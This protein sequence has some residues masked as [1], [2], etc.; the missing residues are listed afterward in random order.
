MK[1][2]FHK[3]MAISM[4]FVVLFSTMSFSVGLHYCGNTL[5][6]TALFEKAKSCGMEL[7]KKTSSSN[8]PVMEKNCCHD[9]EIL[10]KGQ[11]ELKISFDSL[12]LHQ[13]IFI[14]S[15]VYSYINSFIEP[16]EKGNIFDDYPPPFIVKNIHKLNEVYL[17]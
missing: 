17:I 8:C 3:I 10:I 1:G 9:E 14:T 13:Q 11:N 6:D 15:F 7:Q 12:D 5:V 4:A 16:K 2:V